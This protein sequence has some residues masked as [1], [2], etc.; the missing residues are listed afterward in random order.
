MEKMSTD[1]W[2][3][4]SIYH[5]GAGG[6][7]STAEDYLQF[8]QMLLNGGELNGRRLLSP[9]TIEVMTA[10]QV[11]SLYWLRGVGFGFGFSVIQ[12]P[13]ADDSFSS[14]GTFGWG[15]A[16]GSQYRVDPK[17]RLV[18]V[19]MINQLPNRADIQTK[20]TNLVYQA[21]VK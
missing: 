10:N 7:F 18:I 4:N 13:G 21:L 6:L 17:E 5:S 19:F 2:L 14:V 3:S 1:Q 9:K 12:R 15:G 11:D 8:G 16:Y 20:F